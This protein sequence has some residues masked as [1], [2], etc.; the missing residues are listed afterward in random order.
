MCYKSRR[1]NR[2]DGNLVESG[3][4][5]NGLLRFL[6]QVLSCLQLNSGHQRSFHTWCIGGC[7]GAGVLAPVWVMRWDWAINHRIAWYWQTH[8]ELTSWEKPF[9]FI[10]YVFDLNDIWWTTLTHVE[11][12]THCQCSDYT[13]SIRAQM[14]RYTVVMDGGRWCVC[15]QNLNPILQLLLWIVGNE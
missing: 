13:H 12:H 14:V 3:V 4:L 11:T 15:D 2:S 1:P 10:L 7:G 6:L 9:I 8:G 5:R